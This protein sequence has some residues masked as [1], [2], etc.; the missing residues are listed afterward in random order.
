MELQEAFHSFSNVEGHGIRN[1]T[2]WS[3]ATAGSFLL[4]IDLDHFGGKSMVSESG[5]DI[6]TSTCYLQAEFQAAT[7]AAMR[8]DTWF[9]ADAVLF[10]SPDGSSAQP[11]V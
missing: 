9:H 2:T 4:A 11:L 10:I 6:S 7:T 3:H 1:D 8:A 5:V